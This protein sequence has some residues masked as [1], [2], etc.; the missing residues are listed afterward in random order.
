MKRI[1]LEVTVKIAAI[2]TFLLLPLAPGIAEAVSDQICTKDSDPSPFVRIDSASCGVYKELIGHR[3]GCIHRGRHASRP[4]L[5]R[6]Q[7]PALRRGWVHRDHD[8][9]TGE[10]DGPVDGGVPG[11]WTRSV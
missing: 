11:H 2:I 9:P 1:S 6:A 7:R 4:E 3:G 5:P 10:S 8:P